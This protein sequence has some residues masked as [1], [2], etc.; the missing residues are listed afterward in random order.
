[1][2]TSLSVEIR[3]FG[4]FGL[5]FNSTQVRVPKTPSVEK[6]SLLA[7]AD[8]GAHGHRRGRRWHRCGISM[9]RP[10][11]VDSALADAAQAKIVGVSAVRTRG[12][13]DR[14]P[15]SSSG[16]RGSGCASGSRAWLR[17]S[18]AQAWCCGTCPK[19]RASGA[20]VSAGFGHEWN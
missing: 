8:C 3:S 14:S 11:A 4:S 9:E 10:G 17:G 13:D 6:R 16:V 19:A 2:A 7:Q 12:E 18:R 20:K 1:M 15:T 5:R